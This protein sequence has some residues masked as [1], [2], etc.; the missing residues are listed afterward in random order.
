MFQM[1]GEH[2]KIWNEHLKATLLPLQRKDGAMSGS[3]DPIGD[4]KI[5]VGGRVFSTALGALCLEVYYR[6]A[7]LAHD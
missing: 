2:W 5:P 4:G 3:W 7:K 6:Y 1:G